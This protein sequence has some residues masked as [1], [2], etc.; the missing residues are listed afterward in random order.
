MVAL[1]DLYVETLVDT[2]NFYEAMAVKFQAR[3]PAHVLL[4]HETDLA[5]MFVDDLAMALRKDGW[6]II[7]IDEA[8]R[9][10]IARIEPNT[11]FLGEG[12]I[13]ALAQL[14]GADPRDLVHERTDEGVLER[15]FNERV[16]N[17]RS[18]PCVARNNGEAKS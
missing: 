16:M 6:D 14:K 2:A 15:L 8:Y 4:L 1:R 7:S 10:P 12:R 3:S 17:D 5:A 9:D 13:A 18:P 11:W